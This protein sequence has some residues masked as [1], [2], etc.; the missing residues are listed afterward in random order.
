M[1]PRYNQGYGMGM[2]PRYNQGYGMGMGSGYNQGYGMGP[3][4]GYDQDYGMGM[5]PGFLG[6]PLGFLRNWWNYSVPSFF[7]SPRVNNF[8]RGVGIATVGVIVA[9]SIARALRPLAV[10]A[11]EGVVNVTEEVKG[12]FSDAKEDMED[13]FAE[14]KWDEANTEGGQHQ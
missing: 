2:G 12:I 5:G 3:G 8:F 9:P 13:I 1:G 4:P 6:R 14:A 11:V 10:Q 7:G